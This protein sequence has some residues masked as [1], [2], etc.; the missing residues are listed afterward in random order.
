MLNIRKQLMVKN[1]SWLILCIFIPILLLNVYYIT[2]WSSDMKNQE[3]EKDA[4]FLSLMGQTLDTIL[5]DITQLISLLEFDNEFNNAVEGLMEPGGN[6]SPSRYIYLNSV[7]ENTFRI[8]LAKPYIRSAYFYHEQN[9]EFIF[10]TDGIR[11]L[12]QL[13]DKS[14]LESYSR[15][16]D[17]KNYWAEVRSA[18][19][20]NSPE[21]RIETLSLYRKVPIFVTQPGQGTGVIVMNLETK[22]FDSLISDIPD[23]KNKTI[24]IMDGMGSVLYKTSDAQLSHFLNQEDLDQLSVSGHMVK[25]ADQGSYLVSYVESNH[26]D[27]TYISILPTEKLTQRLD[28]IKRVNVIIVVATILLGIAL[29]YR[30]TAKNYKPVRTLI[31]MIRHYNEGKD[32]SKFHPNKNDEFGYITLHLVRNFI[33]KNEM[34]ESLTQ[35]R[36]LQRET[37]LFALQ[38]QINPHFLYNMLEAINWE[39]IDRM[40]KNNVVSTLLLHLSSNL[41]YVTDHSRPVVTISEDLDNLRKYVY[42]QQIMRDDGF[43]FELNAD[44]RALS[45]STLKLLFQPLVENSIKHGFRNRESRH[46]L[47]VAVQANDS[48][49]LA[50]IVDNGGGMPKEA[51]TKLRNELN[52][53]ESQRSSGLGLRN[54]HQRLQ[55]KYGEEFGLTVK[56]KHGW[57]TVVIIRFPYL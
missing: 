30:Y 26:Y 6:L 22:Y 29:A 11:K 41:R 36:L 5:N 56:S 23:A 12:A 55:L 54:I 7:M 43:T 33:E 38:S 37:E 39:A 31:D 57:G 9:D 42:M 19:I 24:F 53:K 13:E 1:F 46:K 48:V 44:D 47:R 52:H 4:K 45:A 2:Y 14:W 17:K 15:N 27:W 18:E 51:L 25:N 34:K 16:K 35:N 10:T 20:S 28:F 3:I 32:I 21:G 40:G 50:T 49:I 8:F